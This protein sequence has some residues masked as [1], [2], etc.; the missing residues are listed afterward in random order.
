M[1]PFSEATAD[2]KATLE[3]AKR[4]PDYA[5]AVDAFKNQVPHERYHAAIAPPS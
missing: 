4:T 1:T 5:K 3:Q 2:A